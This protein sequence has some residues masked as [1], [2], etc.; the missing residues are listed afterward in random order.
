MSFKNRN[1][2]EGVRDLQKEC[3]DAAV[4]RGWHDQPRETG[5]LL[6]LVHSEISEALEGFRRN[7]VDEHLPSRMNAEVELADAVIRIADLCGLMRFD[8]AGAIRDK[9]DYNQTRADHDRDARAK[10]GGKKF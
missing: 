3:H 6:A 4:E 7:R 9:L 8:L 2:I 1:W 5:T 10:S